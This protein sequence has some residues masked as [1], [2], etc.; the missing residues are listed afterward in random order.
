MRDIID[1]AEAYLSGPQ[2]VID[3]AT[4]FAKERGVD[5]YLDLYRTNSLML[6]IYREG[7]NA[8]PAGAG[9]E[10][11]RE[12]CRLADQNGVEL[13]LDVDKSIPRLVE[14]YGQ[15]GFRGW[16]EGEDDARERAEWARHRAE[17]EEFDKTAEED[18][19]VVLT[20]VRQPGDR[21]VQ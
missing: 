5:L 7:A 17:W 15:F 16:T 6:G 20:M 18:D 12:V 3:A 21:P 13:V 4:A 11:M 9:A 8:G 19:Y 10:V 2:R 14:Y 1:I